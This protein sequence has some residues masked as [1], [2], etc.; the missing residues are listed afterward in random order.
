[1]AK[2][3]INSENIFVSCHKEFAKIQIGNESAK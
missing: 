2:G 1:M 3:D